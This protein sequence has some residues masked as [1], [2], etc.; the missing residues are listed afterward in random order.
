MWAGRALFLPIAKDDVMLCEKTKENNVQHC[1]SET[2]QKSA[3]TN[4]SNQRYGIITM[5]R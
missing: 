5:V 4:E 3:R 2:Y 1:S